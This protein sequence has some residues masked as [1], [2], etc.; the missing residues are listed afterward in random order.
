MIGA[1]PTA[2]L[3][4]ARAPSNAGYIASPW[5][6]NLF[7]IYSP[8]LA[9]ALGVGLSFTVLGEAEFG[10][11]GRENSLMVWFLGPFIMAHLVAVVYRSHLNGAVFRRFPLRFTVVPLALFLA[12][13]S[14]STALVV[15]SVAAT[16]W[17]VYHSAM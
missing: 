5:Y 10:F 9:L 11:R 17:D 4:A 3:A 13:G 16:F 14:S 2:G 15:V 12:M 7:F 1:G 6:D 8:L